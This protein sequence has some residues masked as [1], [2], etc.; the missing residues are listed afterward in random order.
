MTDVVIAWVDGDDPAHKCKKAKYLTGKDETRFDDIAGAMRYRSTGEVY[1]CVASVLRYAPWVRKIFIVT[2]NQDPHIDEFVTR[3]F[4]DNTIPIEIVDHTVLFRGYERHL[5]TF[6]SISIETMLWRIPGL[7][8]RFLY[9]NDDFFLA[10]PTTED[11]W[12]KED[13]THIYALRFATWWGRLLRWG[14]HLGRKHKEFGYKDSMLNAA[15]IMKARCFHLFPHAPQPMRR[16]WYEK[17]YA[18]NPIWIEYNI[19][20]RFREPSQYS[21]PTLFYIGAHREG[22]LEVRSPKGSTCFFKP[23]A[24]KATDYMAR[25]IAEADANKDLKFGCINSLGETTEEA[26]Q[27]FHAWISKRL[28]VTL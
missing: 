21:I 15:D 4:P 5:P 13:N 26:Q 3:N 9:F 17:F 6:N 28:G 16:T 20:H 12:F 19:R 10:A 14:K 2:D 23:S 8:D 1:Y 25:K 22:K 11:M 18:E 24:K 7:S 27:M